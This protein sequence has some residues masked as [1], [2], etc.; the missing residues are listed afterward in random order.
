VLQARLEALQHV[1]PD[2]R[3]QAR[4][5]AGF[6][7]EILPQRHRHDQNVGEQDRT[8]HPE[9]ADRLERDLGRRIAV[10]DQREEAALL[11][12][13]RAIFGQVAPGLAHQP[14]RRNRLSRTLQASRAGAWEDGELR[15]SILIL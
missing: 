13:Q 5:F 14:D 3:C 6:E 15:A 11:L 12:P 7:P 10:V 8:V 4:S 9:A 2:G 1:A